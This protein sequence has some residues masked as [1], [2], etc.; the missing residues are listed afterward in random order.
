MTLTAS[1]DTASRRMVL[2]DALARYERMAEIRAF[3]ERVNA[4]WAEGMI[5]GTTHLALGQEALAVGVAAALA[6]G[7]VVTTTYRCHAIALA[8]GMTVRSVLA[9][10]MGKAEGCIG[11]VGGSM[12]LSCPDVGLLPTFAIVG[13]GLPVAAGAALAFQ[14]RGEDRVAV[15]VFGD[16]AANIGAFHESLNLAAAWTLPV[17]FVIDNNLYGEFSRIE[18]TTPVADLY[19]RAA[20]Y[21]MPGEG[22][23][24]MDSEA[25]RTAMAAA[26]A[27]ARGGQGP[28]LIEAK[29]Y[30]YAGHSR[31]DKAEYRPP[32]ELET[33]LRRDPVARAREALLGQGLADAET[34]DAMNREIRDEI[35][36]IV[37]EVSAGPDPPEDAIWRHVWSGG[38]ADRP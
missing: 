11:G 6:P 26:V 23:D 31:S 14:T 19:E 17:V 21:A 37:A 15:A 8:L 36:R 33:W 2:G 12:H 27:R 3:E 34:L 13:A 5:H 24:G 25:V 35:E 1:G 9:E 28:S 22:V 30:R 32:G 10:V 7:D 29:T 20:A 18:T 16:G 4:L 38:T